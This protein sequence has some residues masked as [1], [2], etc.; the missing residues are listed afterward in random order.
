MKILKVLFHGSLAFLG[1]CYLLGTGLA[2]RAAL[3][4]EAYPPELQRDDY[5]GAGTLAMYFWVPLVITIC[6]VICRRLT[7]SIMRSHVRV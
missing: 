7:V 4:H 5:D 6:W 2:Y 1:F 3:I